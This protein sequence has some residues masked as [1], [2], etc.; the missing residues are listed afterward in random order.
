MTATQ[1]TKETTPNTERAGD[2]D[3][4]GR[5]TKGNAGGPCIAKPIAVIVQGGPGVRWV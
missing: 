2:R 4:Q 5:F 3:K 1:A